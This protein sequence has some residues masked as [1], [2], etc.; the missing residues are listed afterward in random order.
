M[1]H[2]IRIKPHHFVDIVSD[3]GLDCHILAPQAYGFALHTV[4]ARVIA[5]PS[6]FLQMELGADDICKPCCH[7]NNGCCD[8][9]IDIGDRPTAPTSKM[10]YNLLVDQRWCQALNL[11]QDSTLTVTDFCDL[12]RNPN[13][14][15]TSIYPEEPASYI[16]GKRRAI[17]LGIERLLGEQ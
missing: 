10:A 13:L 17:L 1:Q 11:Q 12:L 4:T 3:Y 5:D 7:N 8:D 6:V 9:T 14:D 15:L 16:P 2:V